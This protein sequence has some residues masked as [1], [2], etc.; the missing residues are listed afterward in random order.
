MRR[1]CAPLAIILIAHRLSTIRNA[2]VIFGLEDGRL[3]ESGTHRELIALGGLYKRLYD[4]QFSRSPHGKPYCDARRAD[5]FRQF[6]QAFP[7]LFLD[8]AICKFFIC[9]LVF[10]PE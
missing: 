4:E 8:F 5:E 9:H 2:D 3:V 1:L 10:L 7:T 6:T